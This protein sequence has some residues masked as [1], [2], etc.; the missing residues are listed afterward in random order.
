M[1][2]HVTVLASLLIVV[3]TGITIANDEV[4]PAFREEG[5]DHNDYVASYFNITSLA[6][7]IL[8]LNRAFT[9]FAKKSDKQRVA[10]GRK[11]FIFDPRKLR[12]YA[13]NASGKLVKSGRASG[14]K[15]YCPDVRRACRTPVGSFSIHRKGSRYCKSSKYPLGRG[16]APMP[17]CMF[18][19]RGYAIHG[20]P[21]VP[22]HNASHGCIRVQPGSARWLHGN[23]ITNGTK[24][25]VRSY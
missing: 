11:T 14:G 10:T 1:K 21:D 18:F 3:V 20:S 17:Y 23:F 25:I 12:W 2:G 7:P 22:N 4:V 16:G 5:I 24:V 6:T 15:H 8:P 9:L 19:H 13:Y